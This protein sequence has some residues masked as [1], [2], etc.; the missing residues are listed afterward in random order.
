MAKCCHKPIGSSLWP[1]IFV[2]FLLITIIVVT[3]STLWLY[4]PR[5]IWR[6]FFNDSYLWHVIIFTFWQALLS[7]LLSVIPAIFIAKSLFRRDFPGRIL[8]LRLCS[9]ILVLPTLIVILGILTVYGRMGW[10]S[11]FFQLFDTNYQFTPYGLKGILLT[12]IF[13]N[14]PLAIRMLLLSLESIAV[15]QR[16]L[17][18]QLG[19]NQWQYFCIVEWPYLIRQILS[20]SSL[21]FILCFTSFTTTLVLGGGP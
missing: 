16:Q 4:S 5:I 12:H 8:F 2:S 17:A 21:I 18:V 9:M 14:L 7:T 15:E 6:K 11:Q 1:G 20:T 3:F 19:I 13:F 10:I